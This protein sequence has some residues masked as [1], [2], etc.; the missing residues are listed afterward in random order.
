M[1]AHP[2][3]TKRDAAA[4]SGKRSGRRDCEPAGIAIGTRAHS[5]S[6]FAGDPVARPDTEVGLSFGRLGAFVEDVE[7]LAVDEES[8]SAPSGDLPRHT[9]LN[10]QVHGRCGCGK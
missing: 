4:S 1:P 7:I 2:P 5:Q 6:L 10:E 3:G 8:V 9:P